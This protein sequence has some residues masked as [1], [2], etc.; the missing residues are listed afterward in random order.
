MYRFYCP[1]AVGEGVV[2]KPTYSL[3]SGLFTS[4][5]HPKINVFSKFWPFPVESLSE[6]SLLKYKAV[7][8]GR[9]INA[10]LCGQDH[11]HFTSF[12]NKSPKQYG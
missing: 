11:H 6:R 8:P 10:L 2:P 5:H 7:L 3:I 4:M 12:L 9:L 1:D